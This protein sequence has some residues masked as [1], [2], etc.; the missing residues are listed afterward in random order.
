MGEYD[1]L[2]TGSV[3]SI[4]GKV[5]GYAAGDLVIEFDEF[6]VNDVMD[7]SSTQLDRG[8]FDITRFTEGLRTYYLI[9]PEDNLTNIAQEYKTTVDEIARANHI[10]PEKYIYPGQ[11]LIIPGPTTNPVFDNTF[12]SKGP[13]ATKSGLVNE[14]EQTLSV[15]SIIGKR[16]SVGI[17]YDKIIGPVVT[18]TVS[19]TVT[20][21]PGADP[22]V[23]R[24]VE[25][26]KDGAGDVQIK[27]FKATLKKKM[28]DY[29]PQN[30]SNPDSEKGGADYVTGSVGLS[31]PLVKL[32]LNVSA[33]VDKNGN[34]YFG[35]G[36]AAGI[37]TPI[38]GSINWGHVAKKLDDKQL[39]DFVGGLG[40]NVG[41]YPI[42]AGAG[43]SYSPMNNLV[44]GET[45]FCVYQLIGGGANYTVQLPWKMP[46]YVTDFIV[47]TVPNN[48]FNTEA[49]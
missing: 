9:K 22:E 8:I 4:D 20:G 29:M 24:A 36:P 19:W 38:T 7:M 41:A 48:I 15:S 30:L 27:D 11:Q 42:I 32:G 5:T 35:L 16:N 40:L 21:G 23:Q 18:E 28:A 26:L 37:G 6:E 39:S 46:D 34:T 10:D 13:E 45:G 1:E 14:Y 44:A 43:L 31:T 25:D 49:K 33:T 47:K 3:K 12:G 2:F 17:I